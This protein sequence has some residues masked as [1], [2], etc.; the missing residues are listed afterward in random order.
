MKL[1]PLEKAELARYKKEKKILPADIYDTLEFLCEWTGGIG[2]RTFFQ[3]EVHEGDYVQLPCC[4]HGHARYASYNN[5]DSDLNT[6]LYDLKLYY[7]RN[8]LIVDAY[9]KKRNKENARIPWLDF[10]KAY[11]IVRGKHGT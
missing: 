4:I 3:F 10:C 1:S 6:V 7:N 8:D 5:A 11:N 2:A 9:R